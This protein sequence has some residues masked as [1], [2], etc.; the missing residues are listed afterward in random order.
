M[1]RIRE[2]AVLDESVTVMVVQDRAAV[3]WVRCGAIKAIKKIDDAAGVGLIQ[4]MRE[5][6]EHRPGSGLLI[7]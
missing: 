6:G 5:R 2:V 1:R 3:A 7:A 4:K